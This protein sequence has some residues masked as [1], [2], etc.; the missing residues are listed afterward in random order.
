MKNN[1]ICFNKTAGIVGIMVGV[2][3]ILAYLGYSIAHVSTSTSSRAS[4]TE[5]ALLAKLNKSISH[6]QVQDSSKNYSSLNNNTNKL[7]EGI[8]ELKNIH[9]I[10]VADAEKE[11][12]IVFHLINNTNDNKI[13][14]CKN[15]GLLSFE[16][17][18]QYCKGATFQIQ[19]TII[20]RESMHDLI[21][22][23][24]L[25]NGRLSPVVLPYNE[26]I[27]VQISSSSDDYLGLGMRLKPQRPTP[28]NG[29]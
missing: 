9:R 23:G 27:L 3:L 7:V 22:S 28:S 12:K 8:G 17:L 21:I 19:Q 6:I 18:R 2:F 11:G 25:F 24:V 15:K 4:F 5:N 29:R 13:S 16:N 20:P 1:K 26:L 14:E 10:Y